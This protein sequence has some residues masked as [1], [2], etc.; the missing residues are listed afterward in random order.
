MCLIIAEAGENHMGDMAIAMK[1]I[2]MAKSAGADYVKFQYYN[3]EECSDSDPEKEWFRKVQLDIDKIK[4]LYGYCHDAGIR[5]LCTAWNAE[6]AEDLF[7]LGLKDIKV[8]SF[9]IT[10]YRMLELINKRATNVFLSTGMSSMDEI[11]KAVKMMGKVSLFLLHCV[12]EYPLA[13]ERVNLNTMDFLKKRYRCK[14]GYSDH[15]TGM[16]A[17]VAAVAKGADVIEKHI[18]LS[19]AYPGTDHILSADGPELKTLV[20]YT[21]RIERMLGREEKITTQEELKNQDF[22]RMRFSYHKGKSGI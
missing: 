9:H 17:P 11:D 16:L 20:E 15:T 3:A 18:T 2:D 13:E 7:G 4:Y 19:K 14:V 8:A 22:L 5:F 6:K 21:R 1:L 10:D 12:S